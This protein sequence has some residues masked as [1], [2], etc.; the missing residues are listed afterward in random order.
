MFFASVHFDHDAF[1][2]HALHSLDALEL[3]H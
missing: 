2:H 1:T 3:S